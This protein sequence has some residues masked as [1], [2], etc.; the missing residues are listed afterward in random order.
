MRY[1]I[2]ASLIA[3]LGAGCRGWKPYYVPIE[4]I[5]EQVFIEKGNTLT[6]ERSAYPYFDSSNG[7]SVPTASTSTGKVETFFQERQG[8][9]NPY[10]SPMPHFIGKTLIMF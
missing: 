3:L 5:E 4:P 8:A 7:I 6:L 2:I 10:N 1:L 9:Y